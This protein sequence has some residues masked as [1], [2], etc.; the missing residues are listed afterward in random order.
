MNLEH[1]HTINTETELRDYIEELY[2]QIKSNLP[3]KDKLN[4]MESY[5]NIYEY[6]L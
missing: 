1:L 4:Y 6:T 5:I 2:A 3:L